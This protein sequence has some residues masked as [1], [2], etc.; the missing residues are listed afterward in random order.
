M[1]NKDS[2]NSEIPLTIIENIGKNVLESVAEGVTTELV[3]AIPFVSVITGFSKA[4]TNLKEARYQKNL[5]AFLFESS[6]SKKF[7]EKFFSDKSNA[8]IGLEILSVLEQITLNHQA[9]MLARLTRLWKETKE[10]D[11]DTFHEY[12]NIII[13]FNQHLINEFEKY[14]T[15]KIPSKHSYG[16]LSFTQNGAKF[17]NPVDDKLI[18][19]N[20]FFVVYGFLKKKQSQTVFVGNSPLEE[21]YYLLTDKANFFYNKIFKDNNAENE[22]KNYNRF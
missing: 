17:D 2:N 14:M 16:G 15:M 19:P 6:D 20:M 9:E 11:D 13:N 21:G 4:Y 3:K 12:S 8:E 7:S 10:I 1:K 22:V 5:H 18:Y